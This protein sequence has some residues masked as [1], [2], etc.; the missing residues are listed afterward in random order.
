MGA[1]MDYLKAN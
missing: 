1:Q